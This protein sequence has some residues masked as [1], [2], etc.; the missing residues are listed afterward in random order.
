[1]QVLKRDIRRPPLPINPPSTTD[2]P[3]GHVKQPGSRLLP[4]DIRFDHNHAFP[5][6]DGIKLRADIFRPVTSDT[7]PVPAIISWGPYG[8]TNTG[9]FTLDAFALRSGVRKS[10]QSGYESFEA[11]DPVEWVPRGYAVINVDS[12]G[13]GDSEGDLRFWGSPE[14]QDGHDFIEQIAAQPWCS[15]R[16]AMAG[17]SW[18]AMAQWFIAS[19][20]PP[21]LAC[22][23][24]MEGLSDVLRD[25]IGRGG[26]ENSGFTKMVA[27][28]LMGRG[29]QEDVV[30]MFEKDPFRSEY[31]D[32]K[33]A[34]FSKI[35]VPA[36]IVAS[37]STPLHNPGTFRAFRE[38]LHDKKWLSV[39]STQEWHD[40][41]SEE[42]TEDLAKFFDFY[43]NNIQNGW[44]ETDPATKPAS[45]QHL[46]HGPGELL[47][48]YTFPHKTLLAGPSKLTI[49]LSSDSQD[50]LDIY[51][52]LRKADAHGTLLSSLNMSL[53]DLGVAST[54][55]VP[56]VSSLWY[57]GSSGQLRASRRAVDAELSAPWWQT[58]SHAKE[59]VKLVKCREVV[60]LEVFLWPTGMVFEEGERLVLK[61]AGHSMELADFE[62]LPIVSGYTKT[63]NISSTEFRG[64]LI[65]L[66]GF[67]IL[68][69]VCWLLKYSREES[70]T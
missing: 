6:R 18:L 44:E 58:L 46:N 32:D 13:S 14:G 24:P 45:P 57:I 37:Y 12:R 19:E 28:V 10:K 54:A 1:M 60:R 50:D 11:L 35:Q 31:W 34:D 52:Q 61:V 21:H 56:R 2:L 22:I 43:L 59:D 65:T 7:T 30:G 15:G 67:E 42:R 23:A 8:K 17:N 53:S 16:V 51:V 4:T 39:H 33:R 49:H 70:T 38:I 29:E 25:H 3:A 62:G 55:D 41:C 66:K 48:T 5:M 63:E 9:V 36:Y 64:I 20:Q 69:L 68:L 27:S 47:F 26:I 40:I